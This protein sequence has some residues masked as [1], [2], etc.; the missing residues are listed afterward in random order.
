M[1]QYV[2]SAMNSTLPRPCSQA[3]TCASFTKTTHVNFFGGQ[4]VCPYHST[5]PLPSLIRSLLVDDPGSVSAFFKFQAPKGG[6][7]NLRKSRN[8]TRIR[9][10]PDTAQS[11]HLS[12]TFTLGCGIVICQSRVG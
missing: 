10:P 2:I 1:R 5:L 11:D 4:E 3:Q 6:P 7:E 8:A 9:P 12:N